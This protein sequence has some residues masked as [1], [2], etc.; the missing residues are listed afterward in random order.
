MASSNSWAPRDSCCIHTDRPG[1]QN[2][3]VWHAGITTQPG[4]S[5]WS[6]IFLAQMSQSKYM[7]DGYSQSSFNRSPQQRAVLFRLQLWWEGARAEPG[8]GGGPSRSRGVCAQGWRRAC[9]F[10]A[11]DDI[12]PHCLATLPQPSPAGDNT[13]NAGWREWAPRTAPSSPRHG[14]AFVKFSRFLARDQVAKQIR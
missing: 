6:E 14:R 8:G 10:S 11:C 1:W 13:D 7:P 2:E 3:L 9:Q 4:F 12:R 5:Q